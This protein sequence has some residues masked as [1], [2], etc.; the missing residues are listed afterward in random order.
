MGKPIVK[1]EQTR[2]RETRLSVI[3]FDGDIGHNRLGDTLVDLPQA[4]I[5]FDD[6]ADYEG[7]IELS[8]ND[9]EQL[10]KFAA[11]LTEAAH[12]LRKAREGWRAAGK[13]LG[14]Q[15]LDSSESSQTIF[16]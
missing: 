10:E 7:F 4:N 13:P 14:R 3:V 16:L 12:K 11:Q 6:F 5:S 1:Y 15:D 8:W 9:P 2:S